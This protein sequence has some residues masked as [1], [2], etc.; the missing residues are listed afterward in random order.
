MNDMTLRNHLKE[1]TIADLTKM[2]DES[3]ETDVLRVENGAICIP[4]LDEEGNE[5]YILIQVSV[6]KGRRNGKGSFIPYNGYEEAEEYAETLR[7]DAE[8]K[9]ARLAENQRQ[10]AIAKER[11]AKKYTRNDQPTA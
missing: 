11:A 3:Y 10:V 4:V 5:R 1:K 8:E 6:P 7:Q 9:A 2:L